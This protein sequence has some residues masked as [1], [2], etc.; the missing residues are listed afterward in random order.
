MVERIEQLSKTDST[1]YILLIGASGVGKSSLI[2]LFTGY[3]G[4]RGLY[5]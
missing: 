5:K 1:E 4:I 3:S 2:E